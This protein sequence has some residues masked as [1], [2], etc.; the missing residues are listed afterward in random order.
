MACH[1]TTE[2]SRQVETIKS[3]LDPE[4]IN[5]LG[6]NSHA[7]LGYPLVLLGLTSMTTADKK[8][9]PLALME[10]QVLPLQS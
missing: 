5:L 9:P 4:Y 7:I 2:I 3:I 10:T 1:I 6:Q 8:S